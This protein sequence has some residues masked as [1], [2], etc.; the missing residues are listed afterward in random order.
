MSLPFLHK[1][2]DK[3]EN[4]CSFWGLFACIAELEKK[5]TMTDKSCPIKILLMERL[6]D[7]FPEF[8][9][10]AGEMYLDV[11]QNADAFVH[12]T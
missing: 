12:S 10:A 9:F 2:L 3:K 5:I 8:D 1:E 11:R 4:P 6:L 7:L